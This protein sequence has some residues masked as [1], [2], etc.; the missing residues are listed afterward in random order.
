MSEYQYYEF[1]AIDRPLDAA[2]QA[3]LRAI[4]T[5]ARIS[6]TSFVNSYEWGDL[7]ADPLQLLDRHFD[8]FLYLANWGTRRLALRLPRKHFDP[9]TVERLAV[10]DRINVRSSRSHVILDIEQSEEPDEYEWDDGSGWLASL[11]PLRADLLHGDLRLFHLL[12]LME[13]ETGAIEG[14]AAEPLPNPGPLSAP[15]AALA[16]F[17]G[18]DADLLAAA[19]GDGSPAP[20]EAPGPDRVRAVI[21]GLPDEEKVAYLLR[22][23]D[24]ND[25]HLGLE[26]RK[27]CRDGI[28][29]A[30]DQASKPLRTAREL[31]Q[32]AEEMAGK[33][34]RAA[35]ERAAEERRRRDA[36]AAKA[37]AQRQR[38]LAQRGD[39]AWRDVEELI[40]LRNASSYD[41]AVALLSDLKEIAAAKG[42]DEFPRRVAELA[43]RHGQK[44]QF[45]A[46]LTK[47]GL[48]DDWDPTLG[49]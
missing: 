46:R 17:F 14:D 19:Y 11:A 41:S 49:I 24:G 15:L 43:A 16:E 36:E 21:A 30:S 18:V 33:R 1:L 32:L 5:R 38:A 7:K 40:A 31:M 29:Q 27:R 39:A 45:M 13:A 4:S 42:A 47:S 35:E 20:S 26:L 34:R 2:A 10:G 12:W 8:A 9:A 37:R 48:L 3:E 23:Y 22:L 28:A 25:A 6:S 44:R